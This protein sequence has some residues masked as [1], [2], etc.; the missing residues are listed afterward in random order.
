MKPAH[1]TIKLPSAV[2]SLNAV[3]EFYLSLL[4]YQLYTFTTITRKLYLQEV[5]KNLMGIYFESPGAR[6][7]PLIYQQLSAYDTRPWKICEH[8]INLLQYHRPTGV[9]SFP[10]DAALAQA[11]PLVL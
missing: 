3:G 9:G 1:K 11:F 5:E 10:G 2:T 4:S 7:T 6:R 8:I